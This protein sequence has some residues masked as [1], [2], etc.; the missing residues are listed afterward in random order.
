[1]SLHTAVSLTLDGSGGA[2]TY[3]SAAFRVDGSPQRMGAQVKRK[4]GTGTVLVTL[5]GGWSDS[6]A[7]TATDWADLNLLTAAIGTAQLTEL[8]TAGG[9]SYIFATFPFYRLKFVVATAAAT[10]AAHVE[11]F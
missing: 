11:F 8:K 3:F 2:G 1:M 9:D 5:Q 7:A 6:V 4:T 10:A